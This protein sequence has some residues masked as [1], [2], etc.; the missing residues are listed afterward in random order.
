MERFV[1]QENIRLL[2]GRLASA[3]SEDERR[4]IQLILTAVERELA[5]LDS[6]RGDRLAPGGPP[7]LGA[8]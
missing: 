8:T 5:L 7:G 1:L 6:A 3:D 4:R 2:S